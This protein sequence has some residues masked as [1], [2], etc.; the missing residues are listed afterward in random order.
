MTTFALKPYQEPD[1]WKWIPG[2]ETN[3]P[4]PP[5]NLGVPTLAEIQ[6]VCD[7]EIKRHPFPKDGAE[8]DAQLQELRI[9]AG[10]LDDPNAVAN[11]SP[12]RK[13]I[14]AFLQRRPQPLGAVYDELR[15]ETAPVI[16]TGRELARWFE[17]DTPNLA[18]A[19]AL[20]YL[21]YKENPALKLSPP[22]QAQIWTALNL[23]IYTA[24]LAAWHYKWNEPSTKFKPRPCETDPFQNDPAKRL[25]VLYDFK[26]DGSPVTTPQPFPGTPRHPS[27]PSG[28]SA[29]AGAACELLSL[30]FAAYRSDFDNLADNAGLARMWAGIHYRADHEF[31]VAIGRA[32]GKLIY[33]RVNP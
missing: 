21:I 17:K 5:P 24:L 6:K 12:L 15:A 16:L 23:A 10:L 33:A 4:K 28:H 19:H 26:P 1:A 30:Y 13:P 14:S 22:K 3:P 25:S 8:L 11:A 32:I 31:G 9:L 27:Y 29:I 7:P 18:Y 2:S 20:N